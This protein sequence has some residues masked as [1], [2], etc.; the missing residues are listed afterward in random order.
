[1]IKYFYNLEFFKEN[2][3]NIFKL[4]TFSC[5][6]NALKKKKQA[7]TQPGFRDN[8]NNF[9]ITRCGVKFDDNAVVKK[10]ETVLYCV[11]LE[12]EETI[13][14]IIYDFP[15][16]FGYY[17]TEREANEVAE[18]KKKHSRVGKKHPEN[19]SVDEAHVDKYNSWSKGFVPW[20]E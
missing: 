6:E 4:G 11:W 3:E 15:T 9:K 20:D 2:E 12:Y 17:A 13:D 16:I 19:M 7:E 1:M 8:P 5:I 10:S 18:Y 14:G